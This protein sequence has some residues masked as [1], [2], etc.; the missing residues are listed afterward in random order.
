[1]FSSRA[2]DC[3]TSCESVLEI[4][5]K[6]QAWLTPGPETR[7]VLWFLDTRLSNPE[8]ASSQQYYGDVFLVPSD[9]SFCSQKLYCLMSETKQNKKKR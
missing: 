4:H 3:P 6:M 5:L 8:I 9:G 7:A 1:M 2:A